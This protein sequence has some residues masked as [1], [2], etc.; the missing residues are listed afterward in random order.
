MEVS[1]HDGDYKAVVEMITSVSCQIRSCAR[2]CPFPS[3]RRD[4]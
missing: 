3:L 1:A 4:F 2:G